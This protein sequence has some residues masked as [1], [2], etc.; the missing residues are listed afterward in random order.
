M[1]RIAKAPLLATVL[2]G[3]FAGTAMAT[4]AATGPAAQTNATSNTHAAVHADAV[5]WVR[6]GMAAVQGGGEG[7][8]VSAAAYERAAANYARMRAGP[9]YTAAVQSHYTA[10]RGQA[11]TSVR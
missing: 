3:M 9:E 11:P 8:E 2:I 6:S 10:D 4:T 5:I 7:P 1:L